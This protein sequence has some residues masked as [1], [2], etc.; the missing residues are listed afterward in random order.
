MSYI[1]NNLSRGE[2]ILVRG[3]TAEWVYVPW[4]LILG[5]LSL[6]MLFENIILFIPIPIVMSLIY[7]HYMKI[8][9]AVTNKRILLKYGIISTMTGEIKLEKIEGVNIE[10]GV[11]GTL[12][13]YGTIIFSGTGTNQVYWIDVDE[14]KKVRIAI[15]DA[16]DAYKRKK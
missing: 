14:P 2:K 10:Q 7:L 12:F 1:E 16:L 13:D 11:F 15:E 5:L 6:I 3:M 8:E 4:L 9:M